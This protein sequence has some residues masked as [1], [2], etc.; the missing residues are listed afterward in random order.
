MG[1]YAHSNCTLGN[2]CYDDIYWFKLNAIRVPIYNNVDNTLYN[3]LEVNDINDDNNK[4]TVDSNNL[5]IKT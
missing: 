3:S 5:L 4:L 1:E 2:K